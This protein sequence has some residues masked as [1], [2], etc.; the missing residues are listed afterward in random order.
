MASKQKKTATPKAEAYPRKN[1]PVRF[2]TNHDERGGNIAILLTSP[3]LAAFRII[4][5]MAPSNLRADIDTPSFLAALRDQATAAQHGNLGHTEAMLMNQATGLEA[6]YVR[7]AERAM[8]QKYMQNL[9]V[10]MRMA[11]RAQSQCRATLETLAMIK[12]PPMVYARQA[13]VTTGPQ[14]INNG[15][16]APLRTREIKT[17]QNQL[18]EGGNELLPDTRAQGAESGA[19][20]TLEAV[21]KIDGAKVPRG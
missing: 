2:G 18:S 5:M 8:E 6:L 1:I 16:P 17:E 9:E 20:S 10:Y 7:L 12:N 13:N 3:E 19:N 14:Q 4:S 15:T 21:G 11:L